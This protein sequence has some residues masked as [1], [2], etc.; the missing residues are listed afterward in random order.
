MLKKAVVGELEVGRF[1]VGCYANKATAIAFVGPPKREWVTPENSEL[2]MLMRERPYKLQ[3]MI[4]CG[5]ISSDT[6]EAAFR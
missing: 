5:F 1:A 6:A 2:Y 3:A 4:T